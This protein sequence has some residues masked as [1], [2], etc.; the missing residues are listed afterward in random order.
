MIRREDRDGGERWDRVG[1]LGDGDRMGDR[2]V[3]IGGRGDKKT[4][5]GDR[6]GTIE[7]IE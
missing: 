5:V 6:I 7:G 3:G 1:L 2:V 4:G